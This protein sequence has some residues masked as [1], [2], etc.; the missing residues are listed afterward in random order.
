MNQPMNT[1]NTDQA[2][3]LVAARRRIGDAIAMLDDQLPRLEAA[4]RTLH[5]ARLHR[6]DAA[7]L[8]D[9]YAARLEAVATELRGE[10]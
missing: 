7:G 2:T 5:A 8:L 10:S 6:A 1:T 3:D 9:R 4:S